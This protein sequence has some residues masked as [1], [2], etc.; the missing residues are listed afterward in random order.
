[1]VSLTTMNQTSPSKRLRTIKD[2]AIS[3]KSK[4]LKRAR[5]GFGVR[6]IGVL[7]RKSKDMNEV[8]LSPSSLFGPPFRGTFLFQPQ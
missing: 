7:R 1:M 8:I 2:K 6:F 4:R 5:D 3:R